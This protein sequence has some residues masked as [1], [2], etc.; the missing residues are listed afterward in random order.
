MRKSTQFLSMVFIAIFILTLNSCSKD[1]E[2]SKSSYLTFNGETYEISKGASF[3]DKL[4]DENGDEYDTGGSIL[5][6][7][8][9]LDIQ[10]YDFVGYGCYLEIELSGS[11]KDIIGTYNAWTDN[12]DGPTLGDVR[13]FP[14]SNSDGCSLN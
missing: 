10:D 2:S 7:A 4:L 9:T 8:S 5:L 3:I 6:Y 11:N 1:E 14:E 13:F 12:N